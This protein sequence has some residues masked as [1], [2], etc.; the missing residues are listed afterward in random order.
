MG[1]GDSLGRGVNTMVGKSQD[2]QND[3]MPNH[4][5]KLFLSPFCL[6]NQCHVADSLHIPTDIRLSQP[7][8][9]L[10]ERRVLSYNL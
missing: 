3:H 1:T 7:S 4:R 8:F 9:L 5:L 2:V 10:Q 6:N